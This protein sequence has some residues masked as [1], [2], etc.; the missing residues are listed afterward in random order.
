MRFLLCLILFFTYC[1]PVYVGETDGK[2]YLVRGKD[3]LE[4]G[5]YNDAILSL[6]AAEKEFPLLGDYALLWL[7]DA[8]HEIG[9]HK[10][11]L[12]IIHTLTSKYPASPLIKQSRIREIKE[13]EEVSE[14]NI[15]QLYESYIKDYPDDTEIKYLYARWLKK[16]GK[17]DIATQVFKD[18]YLSAGSFSTMALSELKSSDITAED[19]F[20]KGTNLMNMRDFKSAESV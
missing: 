6:S 11:S 5:K 9:D 19:L 8:Y 1:S 15:Q 4:S 7:S 2:A 12:N 13:A 3:Q 18:I 14:E 16:N 17:D 20:K 10:E